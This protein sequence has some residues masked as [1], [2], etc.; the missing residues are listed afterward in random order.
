MILV[1]NKEEMSKLPKNVIIW[2]ALFVIPNYLAACCS[3]PA[4]VGERDFSTMDLLISTTDMPDGWELRKEPGD[5]TERN[6]L[7]ASGATFIVPDGE[8]GDI[9]S[10]SIA[11]YQNPKEAEQLFKSYFFPS[12]SDPLPSQWQSSTIKASQ[13]NLSCSNRP[14]PFPPTCW[15]AARYEE[16]IVEFMTVMLPSY[17]TIDDLGEVIHAIDSKMMKYLGNSQP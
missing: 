12:T 14:E 8:F 4:Q 7:E 17:M 10:I 15:W 5:I 11:R 13:F 6:M 3:L 2:M 1:R 16:Y 9:A